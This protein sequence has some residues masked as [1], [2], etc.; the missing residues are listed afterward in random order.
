[1]GF[2]SGFKGLNSMHSF[3]SPSQNLTYIT[4]L[5]HICTASFSFRIPL[6]SHAT[7]LLRPFTMT[8]CIDAD[9]KRCLQAG[10]YTRRS[11]CKTPWGPLEQNTVRTELTRLRHASQIT[12]HTAV[13][14][15][16]KTGAQ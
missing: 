4:I 14:L 3:V 12:A 2:N 9:H 1:M 6:V 5:L 8:F 16:T 7:T 13:L 10:S 15:V 11:N